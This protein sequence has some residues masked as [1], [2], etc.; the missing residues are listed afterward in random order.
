MAKVIITSGYFDPL[1]VGHI[2][3]LNKSKELGD[4]L[5]V[6]V[7]NNQQAIIKK[8]KPF[9]DERDRCVIIENLSMVSNVF[10]SVDKDATVCKS[11]EEIA[12]KCSSDDEIFF[13]KGGD[14][15][16]GEIPESKICRKYSIKMVD[17]LGEKIRSSRDYI[18]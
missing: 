5:Y 6:I 8:G 15:F 14:R 7:N 18:N 1:H 3:L 4:V 12:S 10:L 17:G 16:I 13:A 2:E 9:M 11:I